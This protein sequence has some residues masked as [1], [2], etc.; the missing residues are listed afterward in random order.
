MTRWLAP[1]ILTLPLLPGARADQD[2]CDGFGAIVSPQ[3]ISSAD[4]VF[5]GLTRTEALG[6]S[7]AAIGDFNGD[8]DEDLAIGV[9]S[10]DPNGRNSG[11]VLV[12]FGP[13]PAS[14]STD[15]R[16]A[17]LLIAGPLLGARVGWSV[18]A[19]GDVDQDGFDDIIIGANPDPGYSPASL[20]GGAAFLIT[21]SANPPGLL[22]V[23]TD[24]TAIIV[25][26]GAGTLFGVAVAGVGDVNGDG[27]DD[28]AVG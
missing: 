21:G 20:T 5:N 18:S 23:D 2:S 10:A 6:Y 14:G 1:L 15:A 27:F 3:A 4:V 19:A 9:P 17:D 26:G 24:A 12:F 22:T 25:G 28:V 11:G 13:T 16:D 8:G 7:V